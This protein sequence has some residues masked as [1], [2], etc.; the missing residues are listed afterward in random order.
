MPTDRLTRRGLLLGTAAAGLWLAGCGTGATGLGG[1]ARPYARASCVPRASLDPYRRLGASSLVYEP[2]GRE[3]RFFF[4]PGFAVGLQH[5]EAG[6]PADLGARPDELRT[7]GSWTDGGTRCDSWHHAGRAFDLAGVRRD[8]ATLVSCRY[9]RWR[10][11]SATTRRRRERDCW[12]LA[13]GLHE[14]FAY[15]LTY[16]YDAAHANHIHVDDGRS[17]DTG[18][19][20][21]RRSRVQVQAVQAICTHVWDTPVETSGTFD[22]ATRR[23]VTTVLD[24]LSLPD[25]LTAEGAWTGF[26]RRT[27]SAGPG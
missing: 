10:T 11:A 9:D 5:W 12:R 1:E 22:A 26:L 24:R 6:L 21:S 25:D 19:R 8:G 3:S 4:D 13:A 16:L 2:T 23:A 7:Y 14:R 15:V 18:P 27:A 20:F 17:R